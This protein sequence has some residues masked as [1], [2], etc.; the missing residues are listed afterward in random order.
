MAR[1][2]S[3]HQPSG[4]EPMTFIPSMIQRVGTAQPSRASSSA[5]RSMANASRY[6]S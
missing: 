4:R 5:V 3:R 1:V 2:R 6:S